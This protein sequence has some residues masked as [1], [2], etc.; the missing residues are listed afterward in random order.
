MKRKGAFL[1]EE[2]ASV[3]R[4]LL[5]G[6]SHVHSKDYVHRDVKPENIL[7]EGGEAL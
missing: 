5:S 1:E 4:G 6:L 3:I 7:I 2:A